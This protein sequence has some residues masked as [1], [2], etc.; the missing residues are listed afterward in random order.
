M[1]R[2]SANCPHLSKLTGNLIHKMQ[3]P[4]IEKSMVRELSARPAAS[5]GRV[6]A[7]LAVILLLFGV[8]AISIDYGSPAKPL[9]INQ[10]AAVILAQDAFEGITL[11]AKSVVVKDLVSRK[12]LFSKNPDIQLPLASLT[13]VALVLA[14]VESLDPTAIVTIPYDTAPKG[15][16]ER[17]ARG[18]KWRVKDIVD[19]TLVASSNSGADI[20]AAISDKPIREKFAN[21]PEGEAALWR[22]NRIAHE[23]GLERTYFLNVNGLDLSS[24]LSGAYGSA[25]DMA[26]LFSHAVATN[27]P[28]FSGTSENGLILTLPNGRGKTSAFNTNEAVGDI[29]GLIMS[30][31]G[32]TDLAGGNLAIVFD[33]GPAH[34]VVAVVLGSTREGR[35]EDMRAL[36]SAT[37]QAISQAEK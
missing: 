13:K 29:P 12:I 20:L 2:Y 15:S 14:V 10:S 6:F 35:F 9:P 21:A 11:S 37:Q 4:P 25:R 8:I 36:V 26:K 5:H 34:P 30:K 3:T 16:A 17:L 32:I 18:E 7:G 1:I 33:V 27:L 23:L 24:T 28:A 22:M 19:F 31:T